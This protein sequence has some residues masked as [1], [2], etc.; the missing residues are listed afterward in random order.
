MTAWCDAAVGDKGTALAFLIK[1]KVFKE[2]N[3]VAREGVIH[4]NHIDA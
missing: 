2:K 4:L 3:G 1:A